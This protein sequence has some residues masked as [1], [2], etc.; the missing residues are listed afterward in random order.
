MNADKKSPWNDQ[1]TQKLV[2][3]EALFKLLD[4][5]RLLEDIDEIAKHASRQW[6]YFANVTC[7]HAVLFFNEFNTTIDCC[8]GEVSAVDVTTLCAWDEYYRGQRL[9]FLLK[10]DEMTND[11]SP[12]EALRH[13]MLL[14][15]QV[16]PIMRQDR[17]IGILSAGAK[18]E[19]FSELDLKFIFIFGNHLIDRLYDSIIQK[20][21][22]GIL[23]ERASYDALT[24]LLNRGAILE[25]LDNAIELSK[26][27][28]ELVSVI[29]LDIDF[30]KRVNDTYG[31]AGGDLVLKEIAQRLKLFGRMIDHVGR[32]GGEEFVYVM[33][34]SNEEQALATAE[35]LRNSIASTPFS[36]G[37]AAGDEV[38]LTVSLGTATMREV[39]SSAE[40]IQNADKALY[41]SKANGRNQ[42]TPF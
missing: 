24:G 5:I 20:N 23:L 25:K 36:I 22:L 35:R 6:K 31:H 37:N 14:E 42:S 19:P 9:P 32:Y 8:R 41:K 18:S 30:F 40:L 13:P 16:L 12:P 39:E 10:K 28:G 7:W 4:E 21:Y 15:V 2:R 38:A 33:F 26:R 3:Y 27:T 1:T 17:C 29:L 11:F 34:P